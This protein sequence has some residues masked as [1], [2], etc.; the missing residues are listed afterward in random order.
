MCETHAFC[1]DE[2]LEVGDTVEFR[3]YIKNMAQLSD[4]SQL[5]FQVSAQLKV[6]ALIEVALVLDSN[7][8]SLPFPFD[9]LRSVT[10]VPSPTT[11]SSSFAF[12]G[13]SPIP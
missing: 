11:S 4:T 7:V 10:Y 9:V 2:A 3:Y 12:G 6:N 5:S 13:T 1:D 8:P